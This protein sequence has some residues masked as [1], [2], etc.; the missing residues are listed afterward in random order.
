MTLGINKKNGSRFDKN[1]Y[2]NLI[3]HSAKWILVKKL[4]KDG[5]ITA[6]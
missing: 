6:D 2:K 3:N 4:L 1:V 5:L